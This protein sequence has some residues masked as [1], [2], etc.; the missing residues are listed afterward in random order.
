M[1]K[2]TNEIPKFRLLLSPLR[3]LTLTWLLIGFVS[4]LLTALLSS[5]ISKPGPNEVQIGQGFAYLAIGVFILQLAIV[6]IAIMMKRR[7]RDVILLKQRL[8]EIYVSALK[9]S[10]LN[11]QLDS[12]ISHD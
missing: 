12:S 2:F 3:G 6:G 1:R 10:A 9:K 5:F 11:P 4:T 7:N 8:A